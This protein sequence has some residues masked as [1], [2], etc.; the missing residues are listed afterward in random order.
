MKLKSV[1]L[2]NVCQHRDISVA[3][4]PGL[5]AILGPNGVGKSN[6]LKSAYAAITNDFS[7]FH[8]VKSDQ[9]SQ[10][11]ADNQ[12]SYIEVA[13]EHADTNLFIHRG[14]RPNSK[15]LIKDEEDKI[16]N[17][18]KISEELTNILGVSQKILSDYVFVDQWQLF[19]FLSQTTSA[20]AK[21]LQRLFGT[22]HA[23][24]CWKAIGDSISRIVMPVSAIDEDTI[25]QRIKDN[26]KKYHQLQRRKQALD[27]QPQIDVKD[28]EYTDV[29]DAYK[30]RIVLENKL[31]IYEEKKT[32]L[33]SDIVKVKEIIKQDNETLKKLKYRLDKNK[34][35]YE[36]AKKQFNDYQ[37]NSAQRVNLARLKQMLNKLQEEYDA[38]KKPVKGAEY[39]ENLKDYEKQYGSLLDEK[40]ICKQFIELG[41]I[42]TN[43]CP[44]CDTEVGTDHFIHK[45]ADYK[46]RLVDL[47]FE[48]S[49]MAKRIAY[50]KEYREANKDYENFLA[51]YSSHKA[52][53]EQQLNT[54]TI[55]NI[56][57]D[58]LEELN[59]I[60]DDYEEMLDEYEACKDEINLQKVKL[61]TIDGS[62]NTIVSELVRIDEEL[63]KLNVTEKDAQ[64]A[65][66]AIQALIDLQ[67]ENK[68]LQ[69]KLEVI[70][71][72]IEEDEKSLRE[73][74]NIKLRADRTK[75]IISD[76]EEARSIL[77]RECLP[78]IVAQNYL[79]LL[80]DDINEVLESFE[81]PFRVENTDELSFRAIF[82]DGRNVPAEALSGGES[83][84]F[85]IAFR[86]V[87]NSTFASDIGLLCL[88]EPT[89]GLDK[90]NIGCL[91]IALEKLKQLSDSTGLQCILITHEESLIPYFDKVIEL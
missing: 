1:R 31:V 41:D 7:R 50:T 37:T 63:E 68:E 6:L 67:I 33:N 39:V 79:E 59:I 26:R 91:T 17:E 32:K 70:G 58:D 53:I 89:A 61:A 30:R 73:V 15:F 81:S 54:I 8:G 75:L 84:V 4:D 83:A 2:K 77:H 78:K 25:R 57:A 12:K 34:N 69:T 47:E 27:A 35:K 62:F 38:R 72:I 55:K 48:T 65:E 9:I 36:E 56:D 18:N 28:N 29:I 16:T 74:S 20:R 45:V 88:D 44:L 14:L 80:R 87:I 19:S 46:N 21:T 85:A 86:I 43:T 49:I 24:V 13:F 51:N 10:F 22:E 64:K 3:F 66:E 11:A 71:N 5:N 40:A 82:N 76:L 60:V 23:E 42:Q 52:S 90:T